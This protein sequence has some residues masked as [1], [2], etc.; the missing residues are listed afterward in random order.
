MQRSG[1]D[2]AKPQRATFAR[3]VLPKRIKS[4]PVF[5]LVAIWEAFKVATSSL[6]SNKLRTALT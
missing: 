5:R 6:R 4:L 3:A 2:G 1:D